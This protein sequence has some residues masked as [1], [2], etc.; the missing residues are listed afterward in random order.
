MPRVPCQA[1]DR[2]HHLGSYEFCMYLWVDRSP[3][4]PQTNQLRGAGESTPGLILSAFPARKAQAARLS[5][6]VP[7]FSTAA[8]V[9]RKAMTSVCSTS[10]V[11]PT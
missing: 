7:A 6:P 3:Q 5:R 2:S 9:L 8:M 10:A 1:D 11:R 4:R